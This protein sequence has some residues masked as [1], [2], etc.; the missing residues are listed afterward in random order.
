MARYK[1]PQCGYEGPYVLSISG[2]ILPKPYC[3]GCMGLWIQR[4]IHPLEPADLSPI[5][6]VETNPHVVGGS[7]ETT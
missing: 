3:P 1:C 6:P 7:D 2:V 4:N 5:P